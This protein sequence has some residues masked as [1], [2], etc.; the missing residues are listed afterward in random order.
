MIY[1]GKYQG[2]E[3]V[4]ALG[5]Q[6]VWIVLLYAL[7]SVVWNRVTKRLVVLGG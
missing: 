2:S 3:L 7:G 6:F 5:R 1:L 4:F